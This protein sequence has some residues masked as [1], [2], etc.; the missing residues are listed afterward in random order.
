MIGVKAA[1]ADERG[2]SLRGLAAP[3]LALA[4]SAALSAC[5]SMIPS[6]GQPSPAPAPAPPPPPP[7]NALTLGVRPGTAIESLAMA[8][9]DATGA[10][11]AFRQSCPRLL[12]RT[13]KSGLTNADDWRAPCEAAKAWAGHDAPAFIREYFETAQVGDGAAFAT[14]YYEPEIAGSRRPQPGFAVPIYA[15]PPDLVRARPGDA[16][17]LPGG[18]M[19]LGRYDDTGLF[20]PYYTRAEIEAGALAGRGLELAW[21][22]DPAEFFFLQVQGSGRLRAP[23]GSVMRLG[24]AGQNGQPYVGIGAVMRDRGLIGTGPGQYPGSMQGI[25]QYIHDH[26]DDGKALMDLNASFVFF[27][28]ARGDGP[29]GALN[30][31]IHARSTVAVDPLFV[32]LGAPV[33]LSLDRADASGLWIAQDTGGAIRGANRF[34]TFWGAGADAR[35]TAGGMSGHGQALLLLPRGTL[36]RHGLI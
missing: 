23:D 1:T 6:G 3:A 9:A 19:P 5:A 28:D 16:Q 14:G 18:K 15:M 29:V 10:I 13:D 25:V 34:D 17:P 4:L 2:G 7:A 35:L 27:Q 20:V 33:W 12:A 24:F 22:A 8:D 32:P 30:V 11:V 36:A 31:P 26:P 21:A